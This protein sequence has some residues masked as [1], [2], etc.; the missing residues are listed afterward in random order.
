MNLFIDEAKHW[1]KMWSN[2]LAVIVAVALAWAAENTQTVLTM[3]EAIPSPYRAIL[4]FVVTAII[5]ITVRVMR[6]P[7]LTGVRNEAE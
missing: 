1:W 2:Q 4:T 5:P 3:L 6:Q 7:S